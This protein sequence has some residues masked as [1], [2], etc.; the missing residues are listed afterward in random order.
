MINQSQSH[1]SIL[2]HYLRW[3]WKNGL[4]ISAI[5]I[6]NDE[7]NKLLYRVHNVVTQREDIGGFLEGQNGAVRLVQDKENL[8]E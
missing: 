3:F 1:I 8:G 7:K 6:R 4:W 2:R 5:E